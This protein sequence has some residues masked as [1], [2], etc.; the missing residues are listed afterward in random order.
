M[1]IVIEKIHEET[2]EKGYRAIRDVLCRD[3]DIPVNDK[4]VLRLCRILDIKS[5][6]KHK[7]H[8]C[9]RQADN[10][11]YIAQNI[12]NR[13]FR[14]E[15]PNQI[16]LTDV[17]EFKWIEDGTISAPSLTSMTDELSPM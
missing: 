5:T 8:G 7:P 11:Q 3:Y 16:W 14:A 2:P 15:K 12:L 9:T 4:R 6:V 13:N 10:P 1:A 17:S